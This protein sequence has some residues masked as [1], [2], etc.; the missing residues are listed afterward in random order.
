[1]MALAVANPPLAGRMLGELARRPQ[2][3]QQQVGEVCPAGLLNALTVN[4][5][6]T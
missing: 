4:K 6:L 5:H 1:M 2:Q 3:Q